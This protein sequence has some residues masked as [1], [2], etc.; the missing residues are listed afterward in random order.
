MHLANDLGFR[1]IIHE[2][3]EIVHQLADP[4]EAAGGLKR[5]VAGAV[6]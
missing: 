1:Q 3:I 6:R 5:G 4:L 2:L